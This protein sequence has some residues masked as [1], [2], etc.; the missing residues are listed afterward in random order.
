MIG[1]T[2]HQRIPTE[3]VDFVEEGIV[4]TLSA[5]GSD[6]VGVSSL[7][8]GADQM[9]AGIVLRLG[10]RLHVIIPCDKY[11]TTFS[12]DRALQLFRYY[13]DQA[14]KVEKLPYEAPTEEA[15]LRAGYRV[16]DSSQTLVA[17]WDGE[18][19]RGK[20]GTADIVGYARSH[21]VDVV[22]VWPAGFPR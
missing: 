11:E 13:H 6:L 1:V 10:G 16:V 7:A 9:F 20:G 18:G 4:D 19:S 5:Y 22:V 15:F 17:I 2:G 14:E 12:D 8:A 3:A 21:G